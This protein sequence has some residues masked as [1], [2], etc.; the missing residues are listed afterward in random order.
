MHI[1]RPSAPGVIALLAL[2]FALGGTA[3]AAKHYL[4]TSTSQIKPSVLKQLHGQAGPAGIAGPQGAPGA[5]GATGPQGATGPAGPSNLGAIITIEGP[6]HS[7]GA[8]KAENSIA[9]CPA[10]TRAISGGGV[11]ITLNGIAV[12]VAGV[13]R[14]TWGVVA[15]NDTSSTEAT[16][17]AI[18]YCVGTNQAVA[19]SAPK[20]TSV[21]TSQHFEEL[22]AKLTAELQ[23]SKSG[24]PR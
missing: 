24:P 20:A 6:I 1:R 10:G 19:A 18:A 16:V 13:G 15:A 4:I 21:G 23:A 7:I 9:T 2:F 8:F 22:T 3:I 12:S 11:A 5:T 14:E 17:Q